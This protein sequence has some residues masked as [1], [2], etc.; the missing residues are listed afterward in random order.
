LVL[1]STPGERRAQEDELVGQIKKASAV[2]SYSLIS[3]EELKDHQKAKQ[4]ISQG[5]FDGAVVLRLLD[6]Q[7]ETSYVPG[8]TNYWYDGWGY[9]PYQYN[10]GYIVTDTIVRAELSLLTVPDGKLLWV[11]SSTTTNPENAREFALQVAKAAAAELRK[12][13]LLQ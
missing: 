13:G 6:S 9:V 2:P 5:G 8:S 1:N 12:Q 4:K 11:G 7:K 10:P 3:D